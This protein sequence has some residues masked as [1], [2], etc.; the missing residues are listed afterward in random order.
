MRALGLLAAIAAFFVALGLIGNFI[1]SGFFPCMI[2]ASAAAWGTWKWFL[3]KEQEQ[4]NNLLNPPAQ[5]WN[6]PLPIAWGTIHDVL[7]AAKMQTGMGG[8]SSWRIEQADDS[9]GLIAAV[10]NY[11]EHVGGPTSGQ[12]M[13]RTVHVSLALV[14]EGANTKVQANYQVFSA[15]NYDSVRKVVT[16]TQAA[17]NSRAIASKGVN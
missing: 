8:V 4:L 16:D 15:M 12:V 5:V 11:S 2:G 14:P 17:F 6:M 13:P 1:T 10:L 9:R 7:N 3:K